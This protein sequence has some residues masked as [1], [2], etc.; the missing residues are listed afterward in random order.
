MKFYNNLLIESTKSAVIAR[1]DD[2]TEVQIL[3]SIASEQYLSAFDIVIPNKSN[4]EFKDICD[5]WDLF[6]HRL[7][8]ENGLV[9]GATIDGSDAFEYAKFIDLL[10]SYLI[11]DFNF[12]G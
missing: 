12:K 3:V 7:R 11:G 8:I 10:T 1:N 4:Q 9:Y 2:F 5:S 6:G